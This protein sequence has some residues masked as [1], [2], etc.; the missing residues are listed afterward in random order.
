MLTMVSRIQMRRPPGI[1]DRIEEKPHPANFREKPLE[2]GI[3]LESA[4]Q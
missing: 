2:T 3:Y 1:T 4:M